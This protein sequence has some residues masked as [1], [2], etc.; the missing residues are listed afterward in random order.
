MK[1]MPQGLWVASALLLL[2]CGAEVNLGHLDEA[3]GSKSKATWEFIKPGRQMVCARGTEFAFW[4]R[5]GDPEKLVIFFDGGGSCWDAAS[6]AEKSVL[7][8]DK[9]FEGDA[10]YITSGLFD[11]ENAENPYRDWT[12][13]F[14]SNCAGDLFWGD[15]I[16]TYPK[17][18]LS[19]EITIA[20]K[21]FANASTVLGW[22][23]Q[24]YPAPKKILISGG[25]GGAYGS[26]F[27]TPYVVRNYPAAEVVQFSDSGAGVVSSE[28]TRK[29]M[30][31]WGVERNLPPW[32]EELFEFPPE[33]FTYD[34]YYALVARAH[35][36]HRFSQA[37]TA[38]DLVQRF[39][40]LATSG[41]LIWRPRMEEIIADISQKVP[42]FRYYIQGGNAHGITPF[43]S[44]FDAKVQGVLF[45]DWIASLTDGEDTQNVHCSNCLSASFRCPFGVAE[46]WEVPEI[47]PAPATREDAIPKKGLLGIVS[48]IK[49]IAAGHRH[50]CVLLE[51]GAVQCWG[52]NDFGQLGDGTV[53]SRSTPVYV[54]GLKSTAGDLS[55]GAAHTCALLTTGQVQCWGDNSSGQLGDGL[56]AG[57]PVPR[58]VL[59]TGPDT[60]SIVAGAYHTC[61]LSESGQ[62]RCWGHNRYG[63][64]GEGSTV[65]QPQAMQVLGLDAAVDRVSAGRFHTCAVLADHSVHCWGHNGR[66]QLGDGTTTDSMSPVKVSALTGKSSAI[67]CGESHSCA[68]ELDGTMRCWGANGYGQLGDG[69]TTD[70]ALPIPVLGLEGAVVAMAT[71]GYHTCAL[72]SAGTEMC[73][74]ANYDGQLGDGTTINRPTPFEVSGL[75]G[76]VNAIAAGKWHSCALLGPTDLRCWGANSDGQ[77]GDGSTTNH[78]VPVPVQSGRRRL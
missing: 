59:G 71:L 32:I 47:D 21:G 78:L 15:R 44:V 20:H 48:P 54:L 64:L 39:Y 70:S 22:V 75:G 11:L 24:N 73:W 34:T 28:F 30:V 14:I 6:C 69:S 61:A 4:H 18:G 60:T 63:Q 7:F 41:G 8:F 65:S 42:N 5:K 35:P 57:S 26:L 66:G 16:I 23:Y 10:P 49:K 52:Y 36:Q 56:W 37:N 19:P 29:I 43:N 67:Q 53:V 77:L 1:C 25:S 46:T 38:Y 13:V 33:K 17:S 68:L 72:S 31:N 55:A 58:D 27:H 12:F 9:V 2:G 45:T 50:T 40:Y 62:L 51:T 76:G 74:G 3:M